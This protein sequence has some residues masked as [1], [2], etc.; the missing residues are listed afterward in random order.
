MLFPSPLPDFELS[1]QDETA[2]G[3]LMTLRLTLLAGEDRPA[4]RSAVFFLDKALR[5]SHE[6]LKPARSDIL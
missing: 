2:R 5:S 1:G 3:W 4:C 6:F